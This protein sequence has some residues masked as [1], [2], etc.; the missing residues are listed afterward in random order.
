VNGEVAPAQVRPRDVGDERLEC[1]E[2]EFGGSFIEA[3]ARRQKRLPDQLD[4]EQ[5]LPGRI[6]ADYG[7]TKWKVSSLNALLS[8]RETDMTV[9]VTPS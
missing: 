8:P 3:G 1:A 2:R 6:D 9:P 5:R 7:I 4:H